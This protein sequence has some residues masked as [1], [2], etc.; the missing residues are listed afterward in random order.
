MFF[1]LMR[2]LLNGLKLLVLSA[3]RR[4]SFHSR[5]R[6]FVGGLGLVMVTSY[7]AYASVVWV[8]LQLLHY[9]MIVLHLYL[10]SQ[11]ICYAFALLSYNLAIARSNTDIVV[12]AVIILF[13]IDL[14]EQF[15]EVIDAI[16]PQ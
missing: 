15:C 11:S 2:D 4:H 9:V 14:D 16:S 5:C 10:I 8:Q 7:A 13:I 1:H 3:K 6:F 12:N